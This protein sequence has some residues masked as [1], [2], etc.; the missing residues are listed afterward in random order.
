MT[1]AVRRAPRPKRFTAGPPKGVR[2]TVDPGDDAEDW[3]SDAVNLYLPE[4]GLS[5]FYARPGMALLNSGAPL[6]VSGTP[7]RGQGA[8]SHTA[9]DGTSYNFVVMAGKLFRVDS[10]LSTFTDVSPVGITIDAAITTRVYGTSFANQL[11]ITDGVNRPWLATNLSTTP[12]TGTYIDFDS[13]GTTWAAFGPAVVYGGSIFFILSQYNS[14]SARTDLTW[15]VAG[16]AS[17]G[18]QQTNYDNRWTLLQTATN[19]LFALAATNAALYY[20][21]AR[22]IGTI[23][24]AVGPTLASRATH[25]DVGDNIGTE[26]PQ[27]V[28]RYDTTIFFTD[29][30]GRPYRLQE[31]NKP[32]PVW[33]DLRAV[34]DA[35]ATGVPALTRVVTTA[36]F[37]PTLNLYLAAIWSSFSSQSGPPTEAQQFDAKTGKYGGRWIVGP[38]IQI[39]CMG[40][41]VDSA[42]R[43]VLIVL[44]SLL[45]PS[46][47]SLATNGYVWSMNSLAAQGDF[48][49]TEDGTFLTTEDGTSLTTE[50]TPANWQDN[51]AV[52]TISATTARLG[53]D[54]DAIFNVDRVEAL[55]RT[56]APCTV[57]AQTAAVAMTAQGTGTPSTVQDGVSKVIV[58]CDGVQGRGVKVKVAPTTA[59]DQWSLQKVTVH[60]VLTPAGPDEV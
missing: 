8:F 37:E 18:Y 49:T 3:F 11:V 56:T 6:V 47:T 10:T 26:A 46:G 57:S 20:F 39:D 31:G 9:L 23:S 35:A 52:P 17:I 58:G 51:S 1:T 60:G 4:P 15:C 5:G 30:I 21:R 13:G 29:V 2:N 59:S 43:G 44:G 40:T 34:I 36:T 45:A 19:P 32:Q 38:G 27:S 54:E 25:D 22:S 16:D 55:V 24:G 14:V 41:F 42:G 53:Y 48:L 50:G 33:H 12:I 7:F 28:V